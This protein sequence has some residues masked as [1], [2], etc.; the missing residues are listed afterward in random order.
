MNADETTV[1]LGFI[2]GIDRRVGM[3]ERSVSAWMNVLPPELTLSE[4]MAY[5]RE[6]YQESDRAMLPAHLVARH[7]M[8]REPRPQPTNPKD[9][10]CF[11]GYVL[12]EETRNGIEYLA[13]APCPKCRKVAP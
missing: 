3:D 13:A 6:H 7:R 1:L 2:Q 12:V 8:N 10:G 9:H 5:V 11:S 4:A